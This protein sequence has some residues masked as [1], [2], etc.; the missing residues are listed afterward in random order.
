MRP[1]YFIGCAFGVGLGL[2][3][4]WL[5]A[6]W[7]VLRGNA[8]VMHSVMATGHLDRVL[9]ALWPTSIFLAADPEDRSVAIPI[10]SIAL[11]AALYGGVG[12]LVWFGLYRSRAVLAGTIVLL[13]VGWYCLSGWYAGR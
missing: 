4:V 2:P 11:N 3:I 5:I 6:Y 13:L 9:L 7:T 12:W 1:K 10:I 8:D